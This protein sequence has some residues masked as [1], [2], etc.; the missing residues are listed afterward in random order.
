MYHKI[1]DIYNLHFGLIVGTHKIMDR[2]KNLPAEGARVVMGGLPSVFSTLVLSTWRT[3]QNFKGPRFY[4][5]S[6]NNDN[7]RQ[8]ILR[9]PL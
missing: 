1:M 2:I 3:T 5:N 6:G 7:E 8:E 4:C 9:W